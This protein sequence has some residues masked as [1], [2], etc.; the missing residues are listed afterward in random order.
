[1][2]AGYGHFLPFGGVPFELQSSCTLQLVTT[3]CGIVSRD[4]AATI[5]AF[6]P[7]KLAARNEERDTGQAIWVKG[8]V[9]EVYEYEIEVSRSYKNTVTVSQQNE[10]IML[11]HRGMRKSAL[12]VVLTHF[13]HNL[14]RSK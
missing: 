10:I 9:L 2:A 6:P 14:Q 5:G 4:Q 13:L 7:F 1:M 11:P 8:F 3:N 12:A